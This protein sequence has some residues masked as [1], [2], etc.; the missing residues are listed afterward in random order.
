[1]AKPLTHAKPSSSVA[2][3]LELAVGRQAIAPGSGDNVRF[4]REAWASQSPPGSAEGDAIRASNEVHSISR[5]FS[6]TPQADKTLKALLEACG[7]SLG[8]EL[9]QSE[10]LRAILM[11][12]DAA[13]VPILVE[14][15]TI[16]RIKRL[17]NER[18]NAPLQHEMELRLA[19]AILG[20]I[21]AHA[22]M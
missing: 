20:G 3:L 15:R 1:M 5:Q 19:K 18:A 14:I 11:A 10:L 2:G 22:G 12:M 21:R 13:S 7:E 16:G 9:K 6:L 17:K 8:L 4:A